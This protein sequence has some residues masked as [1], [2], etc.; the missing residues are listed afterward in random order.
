MGYD[1]E[2]AVRKSGLRFC[3]SGQ[4]LRLPACRR[5][6]AGGAQGVDEPG[7][8]HPEVLGLEPQFAGLRGG[9]GAFA[10][11]VQQIRFVGRM[12]V[13]GKF[14]EPGRKTRPETLQLPF[15]QFSAAATSPTIRT[16]SR[17]TKS[18]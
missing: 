14:G 8:E 7:P 13:G 15:G 1:E 11:D 10:P 6:S 18:R 16:A 9:R 12:F 2:T 17:A 4:G 3:F 5:S